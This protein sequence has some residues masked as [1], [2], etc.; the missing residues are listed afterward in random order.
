MPNKRLG[1]ITLSDQ[2]GKNHDHRKQPKHKT[3]HF[4]ATRVV[5][6]IA[7][8]VLATILCTLFS[9]HLAQKQDRGQSANRL[10]TSNQRDARSHAKVVASPEIFSLISSLLMP[11]AGSPS[12]T[13][14]SA[15]C[16]TAK[17]AFILGETVCARAI[18]GTAFP[19]RLTFVDPSGFIRQTTTITS[20]P[21]NISFQVPA[22]QT[23]TVG[24]DTVDNRGT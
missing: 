12:V 5:I 17:S 16:A 2:Q 24:N 23:S 18:G 14:F 7:I 19:R 1:D 22:T 15:G 4:A 11:Q 3:Y 9:L 13:T 6:L 8:S 20:D 21:Q 10:V